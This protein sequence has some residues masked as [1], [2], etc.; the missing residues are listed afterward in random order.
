MA[1]SSSPGSK[2]NSPGSKLGQLED[3][4]VD[5]RCCPQAGEACIDSVPRF[6]GEIWV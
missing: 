1:A 2:L 4:A 3:K 6:G 5:Y